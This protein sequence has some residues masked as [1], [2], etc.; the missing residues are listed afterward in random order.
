MGGGIFQTARERQSILPMS[1]PT[2]VPNK[3]PTVVEGTRSKEY[4]R[5]RRR[6]NNNN[7]Y[8]YYYY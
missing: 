8:Y 7:N 4:R 5:R 2:V 1:G 3:S 6:L